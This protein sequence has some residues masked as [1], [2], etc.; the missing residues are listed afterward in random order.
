MQ[1]LHAS[2]FINA[3]RKKVWDTMLEKDTYQQWTKA[4]NPTSTFKG[5]WSEGSKMLFLGTDENG[6]NEGGM[7]SRIAENRQHEFISIEHLGILKNGV[8]DTES[9]EAKVWAPAYENY[10]FTE[11]NG[12]TEVSIDLDIAEQ[13]KEAFEKMTTEALALLKELS[14][15]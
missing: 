3:P 9:E 5:D 1:K 6:E 10:T 4:Y 12:G 8:E 7:V 15:K 11:K 14:E 2:I 13:E